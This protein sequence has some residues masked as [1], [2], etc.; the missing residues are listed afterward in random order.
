MLT[1]CVCIY[2]SLSVGNRHYDML[3]GP[4]HRRCQEF[5]LRMTRNRRNRRIQQLQN[6]TLSAIELA[7][8]PIATVEG[9]ATKKEIATTEEAEVKS[10]KEKE[11]ETT[12]KLG[13]EELRKMQR[14]VSF[15]VSAS[16]IA[17]HHAPE[18]RRR[19]V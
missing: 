11:M 6:D 1:N 12:E 16:F 3:C 14:R 5:C 19:S 8:P 17:P 18:Q 13:L 4:M 10:E 9:T 7:V 2:L 15:N